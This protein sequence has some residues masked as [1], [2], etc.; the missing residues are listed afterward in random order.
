[1]LH[2]YSSVAHGRDDVQQSIGLPRQEDPSGSRLPEANDDDQPDPAPLQ[3]SP[4][5]HH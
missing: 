5:F 3:K 1:M 2:W 4:H